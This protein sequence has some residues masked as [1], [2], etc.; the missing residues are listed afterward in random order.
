MTS[1]MIGKTC[2]SRAFLATAIARVLSHCYKIDWSIITGLMIGITRLLSSSF[3]FLSHPHHCY[4]YYWGIMTSLMIDKTCPNCV[5][6][7][8]M[9]ALVHG[10]VKPTIALS[11][12]SV[13]SSLTARPPS[14]AISTLQQLINMAEKQVWHTRTYELYNI[15]FSLIVKL[16]NTYLC[17]QRVW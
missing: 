11:S 8:V 1:L 4:R 12:S 10:M 9:L 6:L 5:F 13:S 15:C 3:C 14:S 17:Y 7:A 16:P 2:L